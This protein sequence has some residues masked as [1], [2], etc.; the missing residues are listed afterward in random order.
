MLRQDLNRQDLNRE[1]ARVRRG[2]FTLM[3]MLV[4]VI[5]ISILAGIT[6]KLF[7]VNAHWKAK[8]VTIQNL[9]KVRAAIEEYYAQYGTYPPVTGTN[10]SEQAF[11]Y[12]CPPAMQFSP[13]NNYIYL[14]YDKATAITGSHNSGDGLFRFG[15]LSFL[16]DRTANYPGSLS[17]QSNQGVFDPGAPSVYQNLWADSV[18]LP[19][20][21]IGTWASA[22]SGTTHTSTELAFIHRCAL[23]LN[24][25]VVHGSKAYGTFKGL[26]QGQENYDYVN[27]KWTV[28]DGWGREL[29]YRSDPPYR[30]YRIWSDGPNGIP[31]NGQGDDIS[32]GAG[33]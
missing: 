32:T 33:F 24:G 6:F 7:K 17:A 30:S 19:S 5:V 2:G 20:T 12:E 16:V 18:G 4:V 13:V 3:E 21:N 25:I 1:R 8:E 23:Y 28:L 9:G 27:N 15:L 22:N 10:G 14:D 31:E 26:P 11:Y 29:H